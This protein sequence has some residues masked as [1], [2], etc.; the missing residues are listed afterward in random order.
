[1]S[2][3][4]T[5]PS[6]MHRAQACVRRWK[7]A[8]IGH[9]ERLQMSESDL[10]AIAHETYGQVAEQRR[11]PLKNRAEHAD[12]L[13]KGAQRGELYLFGARVEIVDTAHDMS[14][15]GSA[16][17]G[18]QYRDDQLAGVDNSQQAAQ[19]CRVAAGAFGRRADTCPLGTADSPL[20]PVFL[21]APLFLMCARELG[22]DVASL[23]REGGQRYF[24][25]VGGGI[26]YWEGH[27]MIP[28][29]R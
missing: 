19:G 8:N 28:H 17:R 4:Q 23:P 9:P 16:T 29:G 26:R 24:D 18:A 5:P 14:C 2:D 27:R 10:R 21:P 25:W 3:R 11:F 7:E 12:A 22:H 6:M 15:Y 20:H 1:M 13:V